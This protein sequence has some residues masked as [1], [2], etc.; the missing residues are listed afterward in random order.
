MV[1]VNQE[2]LESILNDGMD[3]FVDEVTDF[4][5]RYMPHIKAETFFKKLIYDPDIQIPLIIILAGESLKEDIVFKAYDKLKNS[6]NK[7]FPV[8]N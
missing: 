5:Q 2:E 7:R 6:V 3:L 8:I 1:L 4:F